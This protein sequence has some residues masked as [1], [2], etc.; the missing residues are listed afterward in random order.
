[1]IRHSGEYE[2]AAGSSQTDLSWQSASI[3]QVN[4]RHLALENI[5]ASIRS[6][7]DQ[8]AQGI[9]HQ[10]RLNHNLEYI[11]ASI[12]NPALLP[13]KMQEVEVSQGSIGMAE[14]QRPDIME[15]WKE[16]SAGVVQANRSARRVPV[17][18]RLGSIAQNVNPLGKKSMLGKIQSLSGKAGALLMLKE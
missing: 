4:K 18:H 3:G 9:F 17:R 7:S 11:S 5:F 12:T 2:P 14:G 13:S 15:E 16:H 10:I 6:A 1:L 8:E